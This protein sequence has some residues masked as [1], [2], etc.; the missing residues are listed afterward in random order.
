LLAILRAAERWAPDDALPEN[1][2]VVPRRGR[3]LAQFVDGSTGLHDADTADPAEQ[4]ATEGSRQRRHRARHHRKLI[5]QP[6]VVAQKRVTELRDP[7]L[8]W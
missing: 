2:T 1:A 6:T 5:R 4:A 7:D 8:L 3:L